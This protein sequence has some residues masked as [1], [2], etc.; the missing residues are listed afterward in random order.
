MMRNPI[1]IWEN[2]I[3][4][5]NHQPDIVTK[6]VPLT[7]QELP[8]NAAKKCGGSNH[9]RGQNGIRDMWPTASR[10]KDVLF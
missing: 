3:D 8:A 5:P 2:K 9:F 7:V 6:M 10:Y 4:V 1:L